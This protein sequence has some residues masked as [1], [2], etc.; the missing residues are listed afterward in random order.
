MHQRPIFLG[1]RITP[2]N[3]R[4]L[5]NF[6]ANRRGFWSLW[7]FLFIFLVTIF[8]EFIAND[9]PIMVSYRGELL[10]PVFA[11]YP[12]TKFGG[13]FE[14]EADYRDPFVAELIEAEGWI[15]WPPIRYSYNTINYALPVPAPAPPSAWPCSLTVSGLPWCFA[16]SPAWGFPA[17]TSSA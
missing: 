8:A 12:E 13:D 11:A 1:L 16:P 7:I 2:I 5:D 9:K 4:R 17:S 3:R 6:T 14:T 15:A 10:M